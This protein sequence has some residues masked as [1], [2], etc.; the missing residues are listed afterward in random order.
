MSREWDAHD[1]EELRRMIP[2]LDSVLTWNP[3]TQVYFRAGLLACR[4]TMARFIEQGGTDYDKTI[5][6]S[7]RA[8][9]WPCLGPDPGPPRQLKFDEV[10]EEQPEGKIQHVNTP[11]SI[12]ALARAWAFLVN[13]PTDESMIGQPVPS[14][15]ES[16]A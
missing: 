8:N 9:W 5:A 1:L 6:A 7:V 16:P 13:P 14:P 12:E 2:D 3:V 10:A 15:I 11:P 4:E